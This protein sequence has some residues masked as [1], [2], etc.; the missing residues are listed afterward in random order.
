MAL[1]HGRGVMMTRHKTNGVL[2]FSGNA[3]SVQ[4]TA[5]FASMDE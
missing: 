1:F 3:L 5:I 2:F 4:S